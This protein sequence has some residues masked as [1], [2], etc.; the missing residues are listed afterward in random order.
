[1]NEAQRRQ[2]DEPKTNLIKPNLVC[3]SMMQKKIYSFIEDVWVLQARGAADCLT[4][5]WARI[6]F[7]LMKKTVRENFKNATIDLRY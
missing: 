6:Y 1:M 5:Q 3:R 2:G 7:F 4:K